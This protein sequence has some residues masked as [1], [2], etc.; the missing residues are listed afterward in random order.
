MSDEP[1]KQAD[2]LAA[3]KKK[4]E[5][6]EAKVDPPKSTF[7]PMSDEEW[8]DQMHQAAER[9]MSMAM[10]PSVHQY[11]PMASLPLIV[12][13]LR[14]SHM[15]QPA[16]PAES[17]ARSNLAVAR[18]RRRRQDGLSLGHSQIHRARTGSMQLQSL[19]TSGSEWRGSE[20]SPG[21]ARRACGAPVLDLRTRAA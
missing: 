14:A 3:L 10:P 5:E 12:Q 11:L 18:H 8:R 15:R 13:T 16:R 19:T 4:V 6:L 17:Q 1:N 9:R 2:E 20:I 21:A 7:V